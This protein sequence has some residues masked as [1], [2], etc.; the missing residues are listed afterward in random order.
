VTDALRVLFQETGHRVTTADSVR[1][2]VA[3]CRDDRPDVMLLDITLPDGDGVDVMRQ[4]AGG[5][6]PPT[7]ALTGHDDPVT[8]ARCLEA[9]C[10]EVLVKPVPAR[11][12][13]AKVRSVLGGA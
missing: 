6:A 9:G 11:I 13:L 2:A 8:T 10:A 4:L 1:S 3:A 12:L 5:G 7:F